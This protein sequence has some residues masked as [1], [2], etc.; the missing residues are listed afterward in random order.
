MSVAVDPSKN[1]QTQPAVRSSVSGRSRLGRLTGIQIAA[2]GSYVPDAIVAN[3]NMAALGC[4]SDWI[5]QRTGDSPKTPRCASTSDQRFSTSGRTTVLTTH[6]C[7]YGR[8]GFDHGRHHYSRSCFAS[9]ACHLQKQLGCV[10]PAMDINAA[11]AGFMYALVAAGQFVANGA[12]KCGFWL[13]VL[14]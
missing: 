2:T 7:Q 5:V 6:R 12:A 14:K 13:L 9:T 1:T 3:E 8:G 4:D 10:A 11:C